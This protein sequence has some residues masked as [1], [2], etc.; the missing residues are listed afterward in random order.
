MNITSIADWHQAARSFPDTQAFNVQLGCHFEEIAEMVDQLESDSVS[1][2][3]ELQLLYDSLVRV[4]NKLKSQESTVT[5]VDKKEFLDSLG[6]QVVTSIGT[7]YCAN[8]DIVGALTE[9]DR[10]NWSKFVNGKP[11]FN[12]NGKIIKGPN[13]SKPNLE[14]MY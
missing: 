12:Q 13:Y 9:I 2:D 1:L 3:I 11:I 8:M 5:L 4:S 10:S 14:G 7:A 6:D